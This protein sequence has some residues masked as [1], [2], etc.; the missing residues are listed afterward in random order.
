MSSYP[1]PQFKYIVFH[2]VICILHHL[3]VLYTTNLQ[4]DQLSVGSIAHLVEHCTG[5]TEV[6]GSNLV[7]AW[8]FFRLKFHSCLHVSCVYKWDDHLWLFHFRHLVLHYFK[9]NKLINNYHFTLFNQNGT[10]AVHHKNNFYLQPWST[11]AWWHHPFLHF[12]LPDPSN[13]QWSSLP[14]F[15]LCCNVSEFPHHT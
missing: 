11:V 4:Y 13:S 9:V 12:L 10:Y 3:Q 1:S 5:I 14:S 6:I 7:Q 2:I 8:I 15:H